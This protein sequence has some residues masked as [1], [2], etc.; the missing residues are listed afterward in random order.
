MSATDTVRSFIN[1]LEANETETATNAL[2]DNFMFS[3]WT[4]QPLNKKQFLS[5][6][7]ELKEGIPGLMFNLH[8]LDEQDDIQQGAAV[9][10]N[11][12]VAGYQSD[13]FNI[14]TLSLPPIPQMGK[15]VSLPVEDVSFVVQDEKI[16]RMTVKSTA[17][18]G[19]EGLLHQL[20]TDSPI[21]Q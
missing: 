10:G 13:S 9:H 15:S 5:M 6:I 14:P 11:M 2:T 8:N 12:Q 20:G 3:G 1:A 17:G 21:I 18:G 4:P 19:M 16:A 7:S